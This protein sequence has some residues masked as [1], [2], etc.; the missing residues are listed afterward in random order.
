MEL[1]STQD[2]NDN[3]ITRFKDRVIEAAKLEET[4]FYH[5]MIEQIEN[6]HNIP[7][8]EIAAGLAKMLQGDVPFFLEDKP[9]RPAREDNRDRDRDSRGARND[10]RSE[11]RREPRP[12][13]E[14]SATP[15]EGMTRYRLEVGRSHG[16]RPGNIVGCIAN[17]ANLDSEFI[18]Q[19]NIDDSYSTVDLPSDMPKDAIGD[20]QKAWVCGQQ[21]KIAKMKTI[22]EG[23]AAAAP[24]KRLTRNTS[25]P[26]KDKGK[27][28]RAR[29]PS[30]E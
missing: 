28:R 25:A 21:L 18:Q 7:A 22:G 2:I 27:P 1:P 13:R 24:R 23:G 19:L 29:K 15:N 3:R 30:A 20:L 26:S 16:V 4:K 5:E 12:R 14:R 11:G 6:E 8:V 10:N 17:E 9:Q